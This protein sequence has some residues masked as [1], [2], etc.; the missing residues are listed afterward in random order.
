MRDPSPAAIVAVIGAGVMGSGIA[1]VIATAGLAVRLYDT[2]ALQVPRAMQIIEHGRFGLRRAVARDKLTPGQADAALARIRP[3]ATLAEAVG[4]AGLVIDDLAPPAA[5]LASN[6]A[7]LPITALAWATRRPG[8]VIGWHWA[9]PCPV[10]RMA[11]IIRAPSTTDATVAAVS[12][13]AVL[14]GKNPVVVQD[15]PEVWGFVANRINRAV[16]VEAARVVAEGVATEDQ[17]D[18]I[19]KDCFRWPMGPFEMQRPNS[20]K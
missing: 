4:S 2:D 5:I 19:M 16:R 11:E 17:V 20:L 3:A 8:Q 12:D 7:G 9:Q 6:T 15:Q 18:T 10:M 13:L 14:C 1:Q